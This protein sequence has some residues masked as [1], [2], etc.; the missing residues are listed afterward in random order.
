MRRHI[1]FLG[2]LLLIFFWFWH[3]V[4]AQYIRTQSYLNEH[5]RRMHYALDDWISYL[6]S[7]HITSI[8]V[9]TDYIYF[10]TF[11]GGILRYQLYQNYWDYPFTTSN[12]LSNNFIKEVRYDSRTG[13][14]WAFTR[15]DTCVFKPAEEEW[16]CSSRAHFW[17]EVPPPT[18]PPNN[19]GT[20]RYN[21]FYPEEY[22]SLLPQFFANGNY[23]I[24]GE[25]RVMD[26]YFDEYPI[27]GFL[28]DHWE[29]IWFVIEGLGVGV[30]NMFSQRM[31]IVPFGLTHIAPRV[32]RFQNNDLWI[33]G[34]PLPGPGRPGIV[35][36]RDQDG[37]WEYFRARWLAYL[38]SDNVF[39]IAVTGDSVWFA[40]DYGLS[41]YDKREDRWR[42]F[43]MKH[44]LSS[45]ELT[46]LALWNNTLL[47][48]TRNGLNLLP[49]DSTKIKR[50]K[51]KNVRLATIY[52]IGVQGDTIWIG[53]NRGIF[54]STTPLGKW[55]AV[56]AKTAVQDVP[57]TAVE[58]FGKE[59]W[60]A[61]PGGVF[62]LDTRTQR[63]EGFPQLGL[64]LPG[65]FTDLAVNEKSVWV[66]T[67]QGLLKYDRERKY[68]RLFTIA[69]GLLNNVCR[70]LLLDGDYL[71]I[72][73]YRGIC[74]FYWNNPNRID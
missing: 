62:W 35:H 30:G 64:E 36:W 49:L 2:I 8:A 48:A 45:M 6:E 71:W 27:R 34:E 37:G 63:W 16:Y 25:W 28:K 47:I 54:Y 40:T 1:K 17:N 66:S 73:T 10:G 19:G 33:G 20:I 39:D 44:G 5:Q 70:R 24:T 9:G 12:G 21:V 61:S 43:T 52:Q 22:L 31:D 32:L 59:V 13:Y 46:D 60:F 38:P 50:A 53:T 14:L 29:R 65:P 26:D 3:P 55:V 15:D 74:Q 67:D 68:W 4:S 23:T 18:N 51:A 41:L 42:N 58:V 7:T 72:A 69:D 57:V 56:S 11:G